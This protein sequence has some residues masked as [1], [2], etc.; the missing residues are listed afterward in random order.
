M[1]LFD[2]AVF[3]PVTV[4]IV[5]QRVRRVNVISTI[6]D[7]EA[8]STECV[9]FVYSNIPIDSLVRCKSFIS[10]L[11]LE[12]LLTP[13]Y[14]MSFIVCNPDSHTYANAIYKAD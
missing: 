2:A 13:L 8:Q 4:L 11:S 5:G 1:M 12:S 7:T 9:F 14:F 10:I 6:G 3:T